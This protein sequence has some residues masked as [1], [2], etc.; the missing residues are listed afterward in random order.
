MCASHPFESCAAWRRIFRVP[1]TA[2]W[3]AVA[4]KKCFVCFR[5]RTQVQRP[6]ATIHPSAQTIRD[7]AHGSEPSSP[8]PAQLPRRSVQACLVRHRVA[9]RPLPHTVSFGDFTCA[10]TNG[11]PTRSVEVSVPYCRAAR[12][13]EQG[14]IRSVLFTAI[15]AYFFCR[16][17]DSWSSFFRLPV[18]SSSLRFALAV[19]P[20]RSSVHTAPPPTIPVDVRYLAKSRPSKELV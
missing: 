18:P 15:G 4:T 6:A 11:T 12:R 10:S 2:P 5:M 17:H 20:P 3:P 13:A 19:R 14:A 7:G 1:S 16:Q 8:G 9:L